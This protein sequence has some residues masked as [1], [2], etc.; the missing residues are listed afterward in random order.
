MLLQR[1]TIPIDVRDAAGYTALQ[2]AVQ[3][4]RG[5]LV[6]MLLEFGADPT[7]RRLDERG[8]PM[9]GGDM[10]LGL[11]VS[12]PSSSSGTPAQS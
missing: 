9:P 4:G 10:G 1:C 11:A 2:R 5:E 7:A 3:A 8:M 6:A 12:M